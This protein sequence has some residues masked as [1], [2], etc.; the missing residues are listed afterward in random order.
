MRMLS[1]MKKLLAATAS[2]LCSVAVLPAIAQ[3]EP[4][5]IINAEIHLAG[6]AENPRT[7]RS[8]SIIINDGR[9]VA[10]GA[11]VTPPGDE[12][13]IIDA[14]GMPV[15]PGL[16]APVSALGIEEIGAN[17][18][19]NDR[20]ADRDFPL[21]ASLNAEDA[22]N[23]SS[24]IIPINAAAGVT[25]AYTTP[26]PGGKLFGGCGMVIDLSGSIDP[27]TKSCVAQHVAMGQAGANRAGD[28]KA[29]AIALLRYY[30]NEAQRYAQA[31]E[32]YRYMTNVSELTIPDL[33]ALV[34]YVNGEKPL[35]V[36]VESAPDIRRLIEMQR[37]FGLDLVLLSAREAWMVAEELALADIPVIIN[38]LDNLP[39]RFEAMGATLTNAARLQE[40][41]VRISFFD[42]DIGY[43]HNLRG[44]TQLAGNAVAYGMSH[45]DALAAIT[46][47]PAIIWGL[48]AELGTIQAGKTADIVIW[49]GDPLEL[50]SRPTTVI[51]AGEEI[52]RTTR[53][54]LL[55]QR[56]FD[57]SR[58]DLPIAYQGE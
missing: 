31:P 6:P 53:Q 15:T 16:F 19:G 49:D 27:V 1:E 56:Y 32:D 38:P 33:E 23:T 26:D 21:S 52:D 12:F 40:E 25:R 51:I 39:V 35:L 37:E 9:I 18:E 47:N 42:S 22:L 43:T 4:I 10:V 24:S 5:A 34:P 55:A 20:R 45:E 14:G 2:V 28:T 29:G 8:G 7:I 3:A 13:R 44:M 54:S 30:L 41:G 58:K 57:L 46:L 50:S 11:N 48:E 36:E 17:D